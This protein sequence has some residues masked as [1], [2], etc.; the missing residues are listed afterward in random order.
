[1]KAATIATVIRERLADVGIRA[2]IQYQAI[3]GT[4]LIRIYATGGPEIVWKDGTISVVRHAA[5]G[6]EDQ[7]LAIYLGPLRKSTRR[8]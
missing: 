7:I 6:F 1:M 4:R 5:R 8:G 3:S 2:K